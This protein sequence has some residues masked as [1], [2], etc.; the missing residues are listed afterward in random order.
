MEQKYHD[1]IKSH[2]NEP[3]LIGA[4]VCRLIG[5]GEDDMDCYLIV[6]SPTRGVYWH[7]LVGGYYF[8]DILKTQGVT[9]PLYPVYEGE[10]W[11]DFTRLDSD[12]DRLGVGKE[13]EF[14]VKIES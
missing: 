13:L 6:K 12:L 1:E 9:H 3:I 11:T 4:E 2:F 14:L 7:T 5:Y 10:V 8:L